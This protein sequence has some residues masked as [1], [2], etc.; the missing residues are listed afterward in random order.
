MLKK[1]GRRLQVGILGC[2]RIG[3]AMARRAAGFGMKLLGY[4]V[5]PSEEAKKLG[6]QFVS[7]DELLTRGDFVS[8]HAPLTPETHHLIN[9][10]RLCLM[11]P[12]AYVINT[13]RG[14]YR[15]HWH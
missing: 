10:E 13:S 15:M 6:I 3:Q 9:A 2:G 12:T 1:Q 5:A 4:D 14:D 7:L 11:K 8:V